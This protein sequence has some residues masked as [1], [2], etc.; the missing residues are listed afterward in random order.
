MFSIV[1]TRRRTEPF[2]K[3]LQNLYRFIVQKIISGSE[4]GT[5]IPDPTLP[6]RFGSDRIRIHKTDIKKVETKPKNIS[7]N[8]FCSCRYLSLQY[9]TFTNVVYTRL[10]ILI[11]MYG[12]PNCLFLIHAELYT[13]SPSPPSTSLMWKK[14]FLPSSCS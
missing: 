6:K 10:L 12:N 4:S 1:C 11:L 5:V 13:W 7:Q 14:S 2:K 8:S 3:N 9:C